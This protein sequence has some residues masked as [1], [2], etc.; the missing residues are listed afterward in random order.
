MFPIAIIRPNGEV[1]FRLQSLFFIS[2]FFILYYYFLNRG[3]RVL[4]E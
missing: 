3:S 1:G 2:Y 4:G